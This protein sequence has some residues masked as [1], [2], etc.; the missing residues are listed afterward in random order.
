MVSTH[1]VTLLVD[2]ATPQRKAQRFAVTYGHI[3][4]LEGQHEV[5]IQATSSEHVYACARVSHLH[6]TG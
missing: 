5:E 2:E 4:S 1:G 3:Y 6:D